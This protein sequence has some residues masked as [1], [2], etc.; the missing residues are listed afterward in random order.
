MFFVPFMSTYLIMMPP[1][2]CH[3]TRF[4]LMS[5]V[6]MT[7]IQ[8]GDGGEQYR[9]IVKLVEFWLTVPDWRR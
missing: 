1:A 5:D 6:F 2:F 4:P 3:S 7:T 8:P 9:D